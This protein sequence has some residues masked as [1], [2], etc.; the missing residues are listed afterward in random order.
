MDLNLLKT[1]DAVMKSKSVNEAAEVLNITA[2]AVSHALN[3]LR[4]QYNDPLFTR[5]GRGIVP[6]NFAIEL[7]SE[8]QEPLSFLLNG[9]KSR[10][11]FDPL[12]SQRT[13]RVS[14][15]K[16]IDL[17]LV[18]AVTR[19]KAEHAPHVMVKSDIEH[20]NEADRQDDLR[21]RKVDVIL[22]T[23]PLTEPSYNNEVLFEQ[24]VVIVASKTHP[25]ITDSLTF[26]DY[27]QA[28][29]VI[30]KTERLSTSALDSIAVEGELPIRKVIY[31][32]SSI[33]TAMQLVS[34]T[35]WIAAC[36]KGHADKLAERLDL[37]VFPLPFES[38]KIPVYM[39]WHQS[40]KQDKGHEWF[41]DVLKEIG[42]SL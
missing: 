12:K 32:T 5:Q 37:N 16:D 9:D 3:R 36:G 10:H 24:E 28:H 18:P 8:I 14:S 7:H 23:V 20:L 31:S 29:H 11:N 42:K 1:F 17:L 19:Y 25:T 33:L 21:R 15:H 39:T 26:D 22:A 35:N 6:T 4:D 41:R 40:Q 13:F 27:M 2:S 34:E 38:K 30:W